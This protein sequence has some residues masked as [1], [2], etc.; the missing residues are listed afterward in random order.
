LKNPPKP[1][2]DEVK[3]RRPLPISQRH[4]AR[5]VVGTPSDQQSVPP[6]AKNRQGKT[7]ETNAGENLRRFTEGFDTPDLKPQKNCSTN[8]VKIRH[9]WELR[10][11]KLQH[12]PIALVAEF[13]PAEIARVGAAEL[14][15]TSN[16][17]EGLGCD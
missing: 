10:L 1:D 14:C 9:A 8:S 4:N 3:A 16:F 15:R 13:D 12:K 6:V 7:S 11:N 17:E 2:N 5:Y